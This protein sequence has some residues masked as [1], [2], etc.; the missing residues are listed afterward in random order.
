MATGARVLH[1]SKHSTQLAAL[2]AESK[3]IKFDDF[4]S[5]LKSENQKQLAESHTVQIES[6]SR[7]IEKR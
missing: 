3:G 2:E 5:G 7:A 1:E 6:G 4:L